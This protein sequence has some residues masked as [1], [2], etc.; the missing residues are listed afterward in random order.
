MYNFS[1]PMALM[2]FVPVVFFGVSAAL[3]R[4][5]LYGKMR[6]EVFALFA[7][8]TINIFAAGL[9]KAVWKLLYAVGICDFQALNTMFLPVQSIG[10]FPGRAG[11]CGDDDR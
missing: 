5:D 3:L 11:N 10:F 8:G 2:D 7:A 9:L 6:K 4:H 1:I